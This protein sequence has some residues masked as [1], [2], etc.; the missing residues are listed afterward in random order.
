MSVWQLVI[1]IAS[2]ILPVEVEMNAVVCSYVAIA[3]SNEMKIH[4]RKEH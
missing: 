3:S 1:F 2:L 4:F